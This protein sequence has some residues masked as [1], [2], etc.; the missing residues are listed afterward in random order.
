VTDID[1]MAA[2]ALMALAAAEA[3]AENA[4][5]ERDAALAKLAAA[6]QERDEL[7]SLACEACPVTPC[8]PG[9]HHL[10]A[11]H[12]AELVAA[13]AELDAAWL[14]AGVPVRGMVQLAEVVEQ[15]SARLASAER[16]VE[17]AHIRDPQAPATRAD[18]ARL[19]E[20]IAAVFH[21]A[22][23]AGPGED[24]GWL[25]ARIGDELRK[26]GAK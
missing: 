6:E 1:A 4:E 21:W 17:A 24:V 20:E 15:R 7:G 14:A 13:K 3:R 22:S 25:M 19:R 5:R 11:Q 12:R 2:Q 8:G 26:G 16:V 9:E 10:C 23:G 18:L